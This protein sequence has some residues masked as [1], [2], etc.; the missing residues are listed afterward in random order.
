MLLFPQTVST[1]YLNGNLPTAHIVYKNLQSQH[2]QHV[3]YIELCRWFLQI[4]CQII[5]LIFI[6]LLE[7]SVLR[8]RIYICNNSI[9]IYIL[10]FN[11][12]LNVHKSFLTLSLCAG[13]SYHRK[14]PY[15]W[16][17]IFYFNSYNRIPK[18]MFINTVTNHH[19]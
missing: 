18:Y 6:Y 3:G 17:W 12:G 14:M 4:R 13:K 9:E 16:V 10:N 5:G 7:L 11:F 1:I 15:W 8:S 19:T 2:F